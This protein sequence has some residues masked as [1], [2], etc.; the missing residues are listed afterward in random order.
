MQPCNSAILNIYS[1]RLEDLSEET[2]KKIYIYYI[3]S[4]VKSHNA[5]DACMKYITERDG[6]HVYF[7][8]G[9]PCESRLQ[10]LFC[11][12]KYPD[13]KIHITPLVRLD[14]CDIVVAEA[15]HL[16]TRVSCVNC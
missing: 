2:K 14:K 16:F 13:D 12:D 5:Y 7:L 10:G 1:I 15:M 3:L 6:S 9:A 4:G 8:Y 11:E